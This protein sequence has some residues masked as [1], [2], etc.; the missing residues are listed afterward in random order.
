MELICLGSL[1]ERLS[2]IRR[3]LEGQN[4]ISEWCCF[5]SWTS[6]WSKK[7]KNWRPQCTRQ[8]VGGVWRSATLFSDLW[9][10]SECL[11]SLWL[12]VLTV[13]AVTIHFCQQGAPFMTSLNRVGGLCRNDGKNPS[14]LG[15]GW[16]LG[17]MAHPRQVLC[18]KTLLLEWP[19]GLV[20][21]E[22]FK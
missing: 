9:L 3:Q 12:I 7:K 22:Y 11:W 16:R 10:I 8:S 21:L 17:K 18:W 13:S 5:R 6:G 19:K 20:L 2:N 4:S 15:D 14:Q 1:L